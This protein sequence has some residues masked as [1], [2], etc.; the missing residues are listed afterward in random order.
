MTSTHL[1]ST[2][3]AP[4][5]QYKIQCN[6]GSVLIGDREFLSATDALE[7]YL[8]QYD[9]Q[10]FFNSQSTYKR[11][12]GDLLN[13]K[14]PL[15]MTAERS[16]ETGVRATDTELRL[17]DQRDSIN[18]SLLHMKK[19]V[20]LKAEGKLLIINNLTLA[21]CSYVEDCVFKLLITR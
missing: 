10:G 21:S 14:S 16:L 11:T 13:P 3:G 7:A 20:S 4:T 5:S 1:P 17:A 15:R 8:S 12:V 6:T 2:L 9:S 19:S 18:E